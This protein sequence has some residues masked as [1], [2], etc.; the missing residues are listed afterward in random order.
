[1]KKVLLAKKRFFIF[2]DVYCPKKGINFFKGKIKIKPFLAMSL[3]YESISEDIL[4]H[5]ARFSKNL[6]DWIRC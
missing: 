1:M 2:E 4:G 6:F 3:I 5:S